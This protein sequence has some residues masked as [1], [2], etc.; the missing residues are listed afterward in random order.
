MNYFYKSGGSGLSGGLGSLRTGGGT[1]NAPSEGRYGVL[2]NGRTEFI[3]Q[4][5]KIYKKD[6]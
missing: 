2:L 3:G 5:G 1:V 6:L 4:D